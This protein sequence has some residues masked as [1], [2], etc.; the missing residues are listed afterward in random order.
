MSNNRVIS[1]IDFFT[2]V[3]EEIKEGKSVTI[4]FK[5]NSMYP[6]IRSDKYIITLTP[7]KEELK[8][9]DIAL[10]KYRGE[11]LLHRLIEIKGNKYLFRGDGSIIQEELVERADIIAIL[12]RITTLDGKECR[13]DTFF[14]KQSHKLWQKLFPIRRYLI[15]ILRIFFK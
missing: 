2:L 10:F 5:G 13:R 8:I 6:F 4:P 9:N 1:N 15:R 7:I 11:H 3:E 14:W 12:A